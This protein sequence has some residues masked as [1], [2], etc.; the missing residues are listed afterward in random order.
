[1]T[2]VMAGR[3]MWAPGGMGSRGGAEQQGAA[4]QSGPTAPI[5]ARRATSDETDMT[6]LLRLDS[7]T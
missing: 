6:N 1:M 7:L 2:V 3:P 5:A 4:D